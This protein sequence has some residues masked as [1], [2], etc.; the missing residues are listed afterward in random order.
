MS[1]S[2]T[3]NES[4]AFFKVPTLTGLDDFAQWKSAMTDSLLMLGA[5]DIVEGTEP[6]LLAIKYEDGKETVEGKKEVNSWNERNRKAMA[7]MRRTVSDALKV[8]SEDCRSAMEIW[9]RLCEL[10]DLTAP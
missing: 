7:I 4:A 5:L 2:I 1:G 3:G 10:H 9:D 6:R 8:D